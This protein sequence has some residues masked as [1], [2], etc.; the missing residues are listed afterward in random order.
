MKTRTRSL[1]LKGGPFRHALSISYMSRV[2]SL[3]TGVPVD[4]LSSTRLFEKLAVSFASGE[5]I[6]ERESGKRERSWAQRRKEG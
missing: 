1:S 6:V 5:G 2:R 4:S 3:G